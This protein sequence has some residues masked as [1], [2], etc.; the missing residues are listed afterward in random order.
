MVFPHN[1]T[2]AAVAEPSPA[3]RVR[4]LAE[5]VARPTAALRD[6]DRDRR[7]DPR[8]FAELAGARPGLGL[9]GP[10]VPRSAGGSGLSATQTCSLLEGLGE[11]S[12]DPGLALAVG[13]HAVLATVPLRAF[14]SLQQRERYLPRMASGEWVGG[15]SLRQT[16]GSAFA[17]TVVARPTASGAGGWV[18]TG[19]LDLVAGAP[20]AHHFL[21]IAAHDDS[22]SGGRTAFVVDRDTLGLLITDAGPAAMR[23][24]PWGRL[25]LNGCPVPDDAVLG[26]VGGATAE[27][28]PLLAA[29]DWVFSSAPWLGVMRALTRDAIDAARELHLFGQPLAHT[30]SARFTLADLATRCELAA[31]LLYRAAGQFDVGG[32]PSQRDAAVARLFVADAARAVTEGAARLSGP[33]ALTGDHLIERAHRDVLFFAETGGGSSVLQPVIAASLLGLG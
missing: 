26:T 19:E 30:Q 7:W 25:V 31:E 14:G 33:L 18:L 16:Q 27:V 15:L 29:L 2:G 22:G 28:E 21:V 9:A 1:P 13:V 6:R 32:Q 20:V 5:R 17:P 8:L 11:G 3:E 24:C 4:E 23:T 10:L 12:R